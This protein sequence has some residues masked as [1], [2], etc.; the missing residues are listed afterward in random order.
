M[1]WFLY[2]RD[3]RHEKVKPKPTSDMQIYPC[4]VCVLK[5]LKTPLK[6]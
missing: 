6:I 1:N 5:M 3:F 2:V 4:N